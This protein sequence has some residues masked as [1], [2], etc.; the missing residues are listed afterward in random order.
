[1]GEGDRPQFLPPTAEPPTYGSAAHAPA[2][3]GPAAPTARSARP[4]PPPA[5]PGRNYSS[6]DPGAPNRRVAGTPAAP[7]PSNAYA[8]ASVSL[9]VTGLLLLVSFLGILIV[10]LPCSI[11]GWACGRKA[12]DRPGHQG[13]AQAGVVCGIVGTVLGV[14]TTAGWLAVF[15]LEV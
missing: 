11:A 7:E 4:G 12:R 1:M 3:A 10:N 9:S 5:V 14:L 13:I 15:I 6:V 2:I 8:V